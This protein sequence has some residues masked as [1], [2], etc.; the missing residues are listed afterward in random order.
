MH[1][2]AI[3]VTGFLDVIEGLFVVG[4]IGS[5]AVLILSFIEDVKTI[6]S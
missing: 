3:F 1:V 2:A 6:L 4:L 5:T